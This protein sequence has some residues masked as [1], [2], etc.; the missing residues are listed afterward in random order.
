MRQVASAMPEVAPSTR[1]FFVSLLRF[2]AVGFD[3]GDASVVGARVLIVSIML[4]WNR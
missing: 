4:R 1:I 2:G 3:A